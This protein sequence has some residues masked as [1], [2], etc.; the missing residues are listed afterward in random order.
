MNTVIIMIVGGIVLLLL[1][2][3]LYRNFVKS[4]MNK[5]ENKSLKRGIELSRKMAERNAQIEKELELEQYGDG[6]DMH[7]D[8]DTLIDKLRD[9]TDK[10]NNRPKRS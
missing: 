2:I 8:F 10:F 4:G 3:Y 5:Q 6:V 9:K 1:L 7:P